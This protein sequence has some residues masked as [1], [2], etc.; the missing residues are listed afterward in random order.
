[1]SDIETFSL[2]LGILGTLAAI[3][4]GY[5]AYKRSY[6]SDNKEEGMQDGVVLTELG[7]IK[8]GIDD[9]KHKQEFQDKQFL[10]IV[11]RLS[12]AE[13]SVSYAHNRI[14]DIERRKDG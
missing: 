10:E 6:K 5:I 7:Y 3:I 9:I 2:I 14:N 1:M 4:F 13:K 11:Q 12:A 8:S